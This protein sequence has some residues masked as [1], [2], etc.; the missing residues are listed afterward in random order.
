MDGE[1]VRTTFHLGSF[2]LA[3]Q[4]QKIACL[5]QLSATHSYFKE[6]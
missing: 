3:Q 6:R 5:A 2:F 1:D 4:D